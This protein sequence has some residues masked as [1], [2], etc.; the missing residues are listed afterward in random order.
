MQED[1]VIEE[2]NMYW[3]F[4]LCSNFY[5][6]LAANLTTPTT[7]NMK[8]DIIFNPGH[9]KSFLVSLHTLTYQVKICLQLGRREDKAISWS[10]ASLILKLLSSSTASLFCQ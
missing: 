7:Q 8:D 3:V 5:S 2:K 6:V 9:D 10:M 4:L 1:Q